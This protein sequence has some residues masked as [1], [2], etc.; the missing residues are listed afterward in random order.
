MKVGRSL[1]QRKKI[2][3][4]IYIILWVSLFIHAVSLIIS[5]FFITDWRFV[6]DPI[7][8]IVEFLGSI[9]AFYV[10]S[11]LLKQEKI[12]KGT[13]F[14][15]SIAIALIGM[16]VFDGLHAFFHAGKSFV[17]FHSLSTL[18][19]GLLFSVVWFE[20][21]IEF[22]KRKKF[23]NI[24][25]FLTFILSIFFLFFP[26][27]IPPMVIDGQFSSLAIFFNVFGGLLLIL[28]SGKI[29]FTFRK[30]QSTDDQ[31]FV[32]H[33]LLFG[34]AATMFQ[35]S[36]LWDFSWWSWHLL[37]LGAYITA[38]YF[39]YKQE[40]EIRVK[41]IETERSKNAQASFMANISHEIRTP[42]NGIMGG[43]TD[44]K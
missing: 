42:L 34:L 22:F 32:L 20:G 28:A 38:Y 7:H 5:K 33:C 40:E 19:G 14:N 2:S 3:K 37:R 12:H 29:F 13:S 26:E 1:N 24:A 35:E 18:W 9:I 41:L 10:A 36:K 16:G 44:S 21:K 43:G 17:F 39:A 11:V 6:H 31:L 8:A 27:S 25:L 30:N 23:L 4:T 15:N